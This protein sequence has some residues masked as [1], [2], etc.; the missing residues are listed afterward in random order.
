[1]IQNNVQYQQQ[2]PTRVF[3]MSTT[4]RS[5]LEMHYYLKKIG[6]TNNRFMLTLFDADLA[7]ID[8]HDPEL[9]QIQKFKVMRETKC[10]YWYFLR[11]V[12]RIPSSGKPTGDQYELHRGN[13]ALNF[14]L[15]YNLNIFFELPRQQGKSIAAVVWYL[16]VYNFGTANSE[17]TFL[18]KAMKDSKL[19]LQRLKDIRDALPS[20]L[21]LTQAYSVAGKRVKVPDTVETIQ[22]QFTH[23]IIKTTP[24]AKND[25]GAANLLRGRTIPMWWA[26][27]WGFI[28]YNKIIYINT[29]PAFKTAS[30]SAKKM[31]APFGIL[32]T[33]TPG[34]LSTE[35]GK[36]AFRMMDQASNFSE[37]WYDLSYEQI[38]GIINANEASNFVYIKFT[39]KQVGRDEEWFKS[40]CKDMEW[41]WNAIRR[42]VL[43]EWSDAPE[44]SP[45]SK[46][47]LE[48]VGRLVKNPIKQVWLQG[49]KYIL[50]IYEQIDLNR[51]QIPI[52]P[53]IIGV[54]VSGG[55]C[56]DASA[57][58]IIDS[59]TTKVIADF[60]DNSISPI[61]LARVIYEI[62]TTMMPNA[63]INVERNGGYGASVL[64]KLI[65]SKV[66]KNLYFEIKDRVIEETNDG[67]RII[68][69]KQKTKVY[70][71]DSSKNKREL[72]IEI[73]RQRMESHKDK[74]I[75]NVIYNELKFMQVKRNGKVEHSDTSHD[76]QVFSYLM[77]LYVWYEGKNLRE[78]F[79]INKC[80][81][82]TDMNVDEVLEGPLE[83]KYSDIIEEIEYKDN[84][85][86]E[87]VQQELKEM[88]K[89]IGILKSDWNKKEKEKEDAVFKALMQ[90]KHMREQYARQIG[91]SVEEINADFEMDDM[92]L[93]DD[94]FDAS[95]DPTDEDEIRRQLEENFN[96]RNF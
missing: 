91:R 45:F 16:W 36:D 59:K 79:H 13:L 70:G 48:T 81:L 58:T 65:E 83:E 40:I 75:S 89:A 56:Q 87:E 96:F 55:Y 35:E 32:L 24:S 29:V 82:K 63:I 5:F 12:V 31:G 66:K 43:L 15:M 60:K 51:N 25:I 52:N 78:L 71:L 47:D 95:Y 68:R 88:Q 27:E 69:K 17:I 84:E 6:I 62:V 18:N 73:L 49:K 39:Y 76:D 93:P 74:F 21:Q 64:A 7:A 46:E 4:N 26:D 67:I 92:R 80:E 57:I 23:N 19:N 44:N 10:N 85:K 30:L 11:E 42:E 94:A 90:D 86:Q 72:L 53:P 34:I 61:N 41:D 9:N 50:N 28:K 37:R 20:Y 33:T 1:M 3:Q 38:M 54:D 14:C 22:Q 77:A 2:Q 8:P